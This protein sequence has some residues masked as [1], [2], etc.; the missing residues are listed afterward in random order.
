MDLSTEQKGDVMVVSVRAEHLD[1][2]IADEFK[3]DMAPIL[4]DHNFILLD[5]EHLRFVDSAGL[6][7]I[8]SCLRKVNA[9]G[10]DMKLA[11]L[12]KPVRASFEIARMHRI[13]DILDT[14]DEGLKIFKK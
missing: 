5:M 7:A 8:L 10:G 1:A 13:M 4:E 6:G 14:V 2:S 3:R 12:A 9:N 11:N